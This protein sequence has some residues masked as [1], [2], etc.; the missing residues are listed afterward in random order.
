MP[1]GFPAEGLESA[2]HYRPEAGDIFVVSYPKCGTTWLQYIVYLLIR[3]K[4]LEADETLTTVFPHLE[5]VGSEAVRELPKPRL[6]KTHLEF[7]RTPF[8]VD[9]R[10]LVIIRN[11]F[12]C[13][14]SFYHHT[15]GFPRHYD[16][17]DGSFDAFF[18]CFLSGRVDFGDYFDHLES[19]HGQSSRENV[20]IVV[21]EDLRSDAIAAIRQIADFLG[22]PASSAITTDGAVETIVE[23][24][25]LNSMRDNQ[26]RWSSQ[27]P[28]WAEP[29]VRT[30]R[31]GGWQSLMTP[32]QALRLLT[33]FDRRTA[34]TPLSGLWP[35]VMAAARDFAGREA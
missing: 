12:D 15:R 32:G 1:L 9:A 13:A 29:F 27:R 16:F 23:E 21:Y 4:G 34:G 22:E 6:I 31:V 14:V 33:E 20:R 26:Q 30:G 3:Q 8:S 17:A 7:S 19:W 35:K 28:D 10:Y 24:S 25:S 11:P 2:T 18:E 5:E